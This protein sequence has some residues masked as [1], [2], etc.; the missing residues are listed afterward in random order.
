MNMEPFGAQSKPD[1]RHCGLCPRP[2][3]L[4]ENIVNY[5]EFEA[6]SAISRHTEGGALLV[7]VLSDFPLFK[8]ASH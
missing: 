5:L 1:G 2:R 4:G 6:V 7:L 3:H 8:A